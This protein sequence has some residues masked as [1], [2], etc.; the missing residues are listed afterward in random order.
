MFTKYLANDL[1]VIS[2][3]AG[4]VKLG[5]EMAPNWLTACNL[6]NKTSFRMGDDER[7]FMQRVID[8]LCEI[9]PRGQIFRY[10]ESIKGDQH[11]KEW[12]VINLDVLEAQIETALGI[13][14][15]WH[16]RLEAQKELY[17]DSLGEG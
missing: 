11:L 7:G 4:G 2:G 3:E 15:D 13:F 8:D 14:T 12:A 10:P 1:A 16:Y 5:H 17:W 6:A 9:D